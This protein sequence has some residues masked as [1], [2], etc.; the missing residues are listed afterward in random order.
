[1]A[2]AVLPAA[3]AATISGGNSPV[4]MAGLAVP[5]AGVSLAGSGG[6]PPAPINEHAARA[7]MIRPDMTTRPLRH[8]RRPPAAILTALASWSAR[9]VSFRQ[10]GR[11]VHR[12]Q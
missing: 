2:E 10:D 8:I 5:A 12:G 11:I 9:K 4:L 3:T 1:M 7:S 6:S